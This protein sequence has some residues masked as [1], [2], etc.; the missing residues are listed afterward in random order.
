[1]GFDLFRKQLHKRFSALIIVL[2]LVVGTVTLAPQPAN[3]LTIWAPTDTPAV[4][5]DPDTGGVELGTKFRSSVATTVTGVR[6]YKG[7]ANSGTHIGSLWDG[8]GNKL[9]TVTF[10]G[11]SASGWQQASFASPVGISAN[12]T[13][14]VSYHAPNGRYSV[15]E[16]YFSSAHT[17][18]T[19]TAL[20][21][22]TDGGNGVYKYGTTSTFPNESYNQSNY[23]VDVVTSESS[24]TTPPTVSLSSPSNGATVS[25]NVSITATASDN[26]GVSSVQFKVDGNNAGSADTTSP[27]SVTWNSALVSNGSHSITAVATDAAGNSTTSSV[28]TV[29]ANNSA[30]STS[31]IWPN[32]TTPAVLSDSDTS[33]VEL[34]VKFR[35]SVTTS[36][37]G[38]KFYKGSANTGSHVG[39]L[40]DN[41]GTKLATVTFTGETASGWQTANFGTPVTIAPNTTYVIS[42]HAPNGRYS[43]NDGYFATSATTNGTLTALANGTS[44][45]NGVYK[46]G[47]SG[48]PNQTYSS[49]NYWVDVL[50]AD[51]S[52]TT[53]PTVT[54]VIPANNA[55]NVAIDTLVTAVMSESLDQSTVSAST[56]T[57]K[58]SLTQAAISSTISYND[59]SKT[60]SITPLSPLE[61]GTAYEASLS[62]GVKDIAGNALAS[63]YTWSFTTIA[64]TPTQVDPL[65][66]GHDG[67]VL[68]V[69][70]NDNPF[71]TYY[72]EILRSEGIN[73]F[74]TVEIADVNSALLSQYDVV[75]LGDMTLSTTQV[76][77]LTNYVTSGGNLIA[78][79]PDKKLADLLG[80]TD[81]ASTRS[82]AYMQV[83]TAVS[84]GTGIVSDTMQYHGIADNY[85]AQIG[86]ETVAT[87]FSDSTT[88][89]S[90]PAV[91]IRSVGTNGG[92]AVA[93]S[94]DLA[95]SI[96]Y[97]HQGNP[98]W[99]G[100]DRDGSAPIRPNDLFYGAKAGD[101]QP[102]Y[103]NL[104]KVQIPQ[105]D[106]QQ[107][108][109]SNIINDVNDDRKPLPKFAYFPY[110]KKAVVVMVADD[111]A[112][113]TGTVSALNFQLAESA[114]GCSVDDW[115]C[116][117][118]TSLIYT[119][120]PVTD[121]QAQGYY[122]QG[123]DF[124]VHASTGCNDW[125]PTSLTAAYTSE[126]ADFQAKY[127]SLPAQHV[128][129][130]H[131]IAW[132]S[133]A[134]GA[135]IGAS[136]GLRQDLNYY[137][138]PGSWVQ[139]RPGF[140]TGS[141]MN[142][143]YADLDGTLID[144]YQL[145]SHLVNESGQ[146]FPQNINVLLDRALG[147]EGYY[148]AFGT[149]YD[150]SDQFDRQLIASAKARGVPLVSG[151]QMLDWTDARNNSYF[152]N[153]SW[154][155]SNLNFTATVDTNARSMM[156][157][158]LPLSSK[159]G[160]L[161]AI[162]KGGQ[163]VNFTTESIKGVAYAVF[164]TTSGSY[165]AAYG[166]DTTAPTI[167]SIS[168]LNNAQN[169]NV[170]ANV[171]VNFSEPLKT[172]TVNTTNVQLLD[173]QTPVT[174]SVTYAPANN[175]I[176][177]DPS[178]AL[179]P[180]KTYTVSISTAVTD[181]NNVALASAYTSQFTTGITTYS[182]WAPAPQTV[183]TIT[184][185]DAEL[186]IK[187]T[188]S[189]NGSITKVHYYRGINDG[190]TSHIMTLWDN[191][192]TALGTA[193]TSNETTTGWQTAT[194]ASPINI[195]TGVTYTASY[196]SPTGQYS[197]TGASL[198][199][200]IVN[201]PISTAVSG[202]VYK[203]AGG[204]PTSSFNN[205]NYWVDVSFQ[206]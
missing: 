200:P 161:L 24:D 165:T 204:F 90:N 136:A 70:D 178:A 121:A 108:L 168:P 32:T 69:V 103:V 68:V 48:F 19:L 150:Y 88:S 36:V 153:S 8:A 156:R 193:T 59:S 11:E 113:A 91:T 104:S 145:P 21:D 138:W 79:H 177:I 196:R 29:T 205:T 117:R 126:I 158:L 114:S 96:V 115:E 41:A 167:T 60:I 183:S 61:S 47:S 194:F 35:S 179:T 129:R 6:F 148:G 181:A 112:T 101:V 144:T 173:G 89:T 52:D 100:D 18:G 157:S 191:N 67:P 116:I 72:S 155:G 25:G 102:D 49:S 176:M 175:K 30:L 125:T 171:D 13:Y 71:S 197:Y 38:L 99:S 105:A 37:V 56:V 73:S 16:G 7:S 10:S 85:T 33:A 185:A 26:V 206:E 170:Q 27:Y 195:T 198:A 146:T 53:K 106:E 2:A 81:Q 44:G 128:N 92:E 162:T 94:Y 169:V 54:Q 192:G 202:G 40:W 98:A 3:A 154:S 83:N 122:N 159:N 64:S 45:G 34:G 119:N 163:S 97:T 62:T 147:P 160:V 174:A 203:Y 166:Q 199:T 127:T 58:N 131:C 201:G 93:F 17:N 87:L 46:Y 95:K 15:T 134:E 189:Q 63:T 14:V 39:N 28:V 76:T 50:V 51:T 180:N 140:M 20:Q 55:T 43:V 190:L 23:W 139:N 107:R 9:A 186:G 151:Q 82:D 78:M 111:H 187:F 152:T 5:S 149:H 31:S 132:S 77:T 124:G 4:L 22:G 164:T 142:M 135:K 110:N 74:K 172:N 182:F 12:T 188:T 130:I 66:Q 141:G 57:L 80:L 133:Y 42:Y 86:T 184:D 120:T 143:R 75:L 1:M 84:P 137:Y 109:L 123:F 118:S 65:S